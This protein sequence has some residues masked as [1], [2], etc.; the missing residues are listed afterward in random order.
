MLHHEFQTT[1]VAEWW[2][3]DNSTEQLHCEIRQ[4]DKPTYRKIKCMVIES[5]V[6]NAWLAIA[7]END[8]K[9]LLWKDKEFI[10]ENELI[11]EV[12]NWEIS[13]KGQYK[14]SASFEEDLRL[15]VPL[16]NGSAIAIGKSRNRMFF[17]SRH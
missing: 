16:D 12:C 14:D 8:E 10:P 6:E 1:Q 2:Y 5:D 9:V 3:Y 13:L 15:F 4:N 17:L 7:E 11:A